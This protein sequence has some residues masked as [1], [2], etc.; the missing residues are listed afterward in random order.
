MFQ[1]NKAGGE[2][3]QENIVETISQEEI[4]NLKEEYS[5]LSEERKRLIAE[6][7]RSDGT[8]DAVMIGKAKELAVKGREIFFKLEKEGV[9]IDS[10]ITQ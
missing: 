9:K 7:E 8:T 2:P 5:R 3:S 1:P 6:S 4:N 10:D